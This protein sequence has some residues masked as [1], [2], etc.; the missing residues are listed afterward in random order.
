MPDPF[1]AKLAASGW[2]VPAKQRVAYLVTGRDVVPG[3]G[4]RI[5]I[6]GLPSGCGVAEWQL[7]LHPAALGRRG[8]RCIDSR[9]VDA[10]TLEDAL[11]AATAEADRI[12]QQFQARA[13]HVRRS[14]MHTPRAVEA[15]ARPPA[16]PGKARNAYRR[17]RRTATVVLDVDL[18]ERL[19][20][21]T[22]ATGLT[23]QALLVA[24]AELVLARLQEGRPRKAE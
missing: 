16:A 7:R 14:P 20:E 12:A 1:F 22:V 23:M 9:Y 17:G 4:V 19:L 10:K 2:R 18:H 15:P 11:A 6:R 8:H 5:K 13:A 3:G 24:G 21:A